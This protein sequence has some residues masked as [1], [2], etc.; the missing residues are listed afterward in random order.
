MAVR[1]R[2]LGGGVWWRWRRSLWRRRRRALDTCDEQ[3][4]T[5]QAELHQAPKGASLTSLKAPAAEPAAGA[6]SS[7]TLYTLDLGGP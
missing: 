1:R 4:Y 5:G 7:L 2:R 6:A 3:R